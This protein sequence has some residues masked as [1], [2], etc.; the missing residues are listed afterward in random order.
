M[1]GVVRLT[2]AAFAALFDRI[3]RRRVPAER[4]IPT[5][6]TVHRFGNAS[7]QVGSFHANGC[8]AGCAHPTI[9]ETKQWRRGCPAA[10]G[11]NGIHPDMHAGDP[12]ALGWNHKLA[13]GWPTILEG[14]NEVLTP[15]GGSLS[16][17][18]GCPASHPSKTGVDA[19]RQHEAELAL[20]SDLM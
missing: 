4:E 8:H 2:P 20:T 3:D 1:D 11:V 16:V 7:G 12:I 5:P 15:D 9:G 14:G 10:V 19:V 6:S 17:A 13:A 18:Q